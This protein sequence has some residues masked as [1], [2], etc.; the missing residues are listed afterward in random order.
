MLPEQEGPYIRLLAYQWNS[1]DQT[2]PDSDEDLA[3]LSRLNGR[4]ATL[5]P[6]IKACFDAVPDR[7]G[8]LRN[9]RL[10]FEFCKVMKQRSLQSNGGKSAMSKRWHGNKQPISDLQ[11]ANGLEYL[12][13]SLSSSGIQERGVGEGDGRT[14]QVLTDFLNDENP[15]MSKIISAIHAISPEF[16]NIPDAAIKNTLESWPC[17]AAQIKAV[18]SFVRDMMGAISLPKSATRTLNT[19]LSNAEKYEGAK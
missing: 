6:K 15:K 2:I 1:E 19:Y 8:K 9:D 14:N 10:Y 4:W 3:S 17:G 18:K 13:P 7:P 16:R 5:G 11:V 12:T